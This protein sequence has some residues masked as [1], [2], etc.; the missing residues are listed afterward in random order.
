MEHVKCIVNPSY[1]R[2]TNCTN[3]QMEYGAVLSCKTECPY[4]KEGFIIRYRK[5]FFGDKFT[6]LLSDGYI[7]NVSINRIQ[8]ID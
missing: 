1:S 5:G 7:E 6:V 4:K 8:I 2:C 3:T